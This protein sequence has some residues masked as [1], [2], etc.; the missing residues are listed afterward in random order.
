MV[1]NEIRLS[2]SLIAFSF[3]SFLTKALGRFHFRMES[4]SLCIEEVESL[5][6]HN[7]R[8]IMSWKFLV[9]RPYLYTVVCD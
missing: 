4:S 1:T 8:R 5:P 6:S 9:H 7:G 2:M 3:P